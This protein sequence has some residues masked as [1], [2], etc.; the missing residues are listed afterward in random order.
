MRITIDFS[1]SSVLFKSNHKWQILV[2]DIGVAL[3][4]TV[5]AFWGYQRGFAEVGVIYG[6]PYL[7]VNK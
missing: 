3:T 6:L 2:S 7:W 5:L 4:L 1:P